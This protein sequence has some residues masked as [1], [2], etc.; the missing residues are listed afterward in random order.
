MARL[1]GFDDATLKEQFSLTYVRAVV[2]AAGAVVD[3]PTVDRDSTEVGRDYLEV[4][5]SA[6]AHLREQ[7]TEE[8]HDQEITGFVTSLERQVSDNAGTVVIYGF[9]ESGDRPPGLSCSIELTGERHAMAAR[10]HVEHAL[11]SVRG[12]VRRVGNK[13]WLEEPTAFS[14]DTGNE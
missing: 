13:W 2:Y 12:L 1:T 10:A 3:E 14:A 9:L 7:E 11:V 6:A 4:L 5:G 8:L